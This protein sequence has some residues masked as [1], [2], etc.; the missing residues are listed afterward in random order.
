VITAGVMWFNISLGILGRGVMPN[1]ETPDE[2]FPRLVLEYL[3]PGLIGLV[4]AGVLAGGIST[5]DSIGSALAAVFTRDIYARF[6]VRNRADRH[7]LQVSRIA[8]VVVIAISFA[9]I[10]FFGEGMVAFYIRLTNVAVT[11]LF[12]IYLV[13]TLTRVH[14]GSGTFA[15]LI[16]MAYGLVAFLGWENEW[17][18]PVWLIHPRWAY[19][20]SLLTTS[21]TMIGYSLLVGWEAKGAFDGTMTDESTPA[22]TWLETTRREA[23]TMV[24]SEDFFAVERRPWYLSAWFWTCVF[25]L[26]IVTINLVVLW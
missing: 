11:P 22:D 4:V 9:Y 23:A 18:L 1:L 6:F 24:S 25:L 12:T 21:A 7:Y 8:T 10:P 3:G 16:G 14:R 19:L 26:A 13:G 2:I 17:D 5:Y 20:W 15:L